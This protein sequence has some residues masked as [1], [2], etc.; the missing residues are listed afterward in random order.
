MKNQINYPLSWRMSKKSAEKEV[1]KNGK[2]GTFFASF[3]SKKG[4]CLAFPLKSS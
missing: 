3:F 1:K 4:H 2:N